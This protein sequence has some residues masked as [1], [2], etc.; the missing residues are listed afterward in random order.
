MP[1]R[2][3][4]G[5]P[6]IASEAGVPTFGITDT[7]DAPGNTVSIQII[8]IRQRLDIVLFDRFK[9]AQSHQLRSNT[10]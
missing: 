7:A 4:F 6:P 8:R 5:L 9:Q 3:L 2:C 1:N 10:R